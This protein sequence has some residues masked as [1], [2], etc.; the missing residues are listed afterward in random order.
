MNDEQLAKMYPTMVQTDNRQANTDSN[1]AAPEVTSSQ[2]GKDAQSLS[3]EQ[4][5]T[6][7]YEKNAAERDAKTAETQEIG[8]GGRFARIR[9]D[10][11]TGLETFFDSRELKEEDRQAAT[12]S[13]RSLAADL[14]LQ[15][16]DLMQVIGELNK[17]TPTAE[18]QSKWA[19][20]VIK[21]LSEQYGERDA[22]HLITDA[23]AWL[24][25]HHPDIQALLVQAGIGS[26]PQIARTVIN[27]V[28]SYR[29]RHA[30]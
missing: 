28:R 22:L 30:G 15:Q 16:N 5:L 1:V 17:D 7:W 21:S 20:Q 14:N 29:M 24:K 18:T 11:Y 27:A 8:D 26:H 25:E 3:A 19:E 9:E 23:K 2:Q 6:N 4:K 12:Y 10:R 13:L